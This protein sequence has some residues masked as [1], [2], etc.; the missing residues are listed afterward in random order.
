MS[1]NRWARLLKECFQLRIM[2]V[3]NQRV[4]DG[5]EHRLVVGHLVGDVGPVKRR[6]ALPLQCI[7]VLLTALPE[8]L[9]GRI[10]LRRYS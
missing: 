3:G 9:T 5:V 10:L 4:V 1:R 6:S 8:L 2:R 7:A